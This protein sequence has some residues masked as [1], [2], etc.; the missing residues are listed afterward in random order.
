VISLLGRRAAVRVSAHLESS[1]VEEWLQALSEGR[2]SPF[3]TRQG[4]AL[5]VAGSVLASRELWDPGV[6]TAGEGGPR[7]DVLRAWQ[8]GPRATG[9]IVRQGGKRPP[10]SGKHQGW[11][12]PLPP[13]LSAG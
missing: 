12:A 6:R 5:A 7:G 2:A 9:R 3:T 10:V 13:S 4:R 8:V 11:L 1:A